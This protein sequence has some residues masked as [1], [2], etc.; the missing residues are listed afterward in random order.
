LL[1]NNPDAPGLYAWKIARDCGG[2]PACLE[3]STSGCPEGVPV[4]GAMDI[5]FR[6]YLEPSTGTAADPSTLVIDR[7]MRF[8]K[9]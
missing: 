6:V 4:G 7:V 8:Q 1:S 2:D 5:A 3:V 9:K